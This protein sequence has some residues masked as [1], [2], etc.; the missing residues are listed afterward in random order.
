LSE[1]SHIRWLQELA[2]ILKPNGVMLHSVKSPLALRR[3]ELFSPENLL[4]YRDNSIKN[5]ETDISYHYILDNPSNPE[6]GQ[7]I[8]NKD[9]ILKNWPVYS[10]LKIIDFQEGWIE[11]YPE[12]CHDLILMGK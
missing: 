2:R 4:K 8:I 10:G 12:G 5:Y 1:E 7:T 11:A 3:M 6:Y 9:Y